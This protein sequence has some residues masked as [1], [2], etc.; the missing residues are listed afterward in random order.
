M[1]AEGKKERKTGPAKGAWSPEFWH[2]AVPGFELADEARQVYELILGA[3]RA[4]KRS[5]P[6]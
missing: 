5:A 2:Q 3:Q 6:V 1:T 4:A